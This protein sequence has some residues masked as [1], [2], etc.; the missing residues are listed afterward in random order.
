MVPWYAEIAE[1][2]P[3]VVL[4]GLLIAR[5]DKIKKDGAILLVSGIA[6]ILLMVSMIFS[7]PSEIVVS[8]TALSETSQSAIE[9]A[10]KVAIESIPKSLQKRKYRIF[11]GGGL[12]DD[13]KNGVNVVKTN[14]MYR[15]T[16]TLEVDQ[17]ALD[18]Q[19]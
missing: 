4:I 16:V 18:G 15:A 2:L 9:L 19:N 10:K 1:W 13:S 14:G 11:V 5:P 12:L 3:I 7:I 17:Y 8:G 6:F